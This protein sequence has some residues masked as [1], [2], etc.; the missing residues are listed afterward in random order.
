MKKI[1]PRNCCLAL[2]LGATSVALASFAWV[3]LCAM[4]IL[5]ALL[6]F[7]EWQ[8]QQTSH[9]DLAASLAAERAARV[10]LEE[11]I[12]TLRTDLTHVANAVG[13]R[14]KGKV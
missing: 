1:T 4:G 2:F 5:A 7:S 13:V 9:D 14:A 3:P 6:A 10:V 11:T 8:A 12:K